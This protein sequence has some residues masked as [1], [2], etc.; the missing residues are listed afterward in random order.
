MQKGRC[1]DTVEGYPEPAVQQKTEGVHWIEFMNRKNWS[2]ISVTFIYTWCYIHSS[3]G[4][5]S[6][7]FQF[8]RLAV[9]LL[10]LCSFFDLSAN[11]SSSVNDQMLQVLLEA[12]IQ[13]LGFLVL[14]WTL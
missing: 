9:Q 1:G 13:D 2:E 4:S 5:S 14:A 11:S 7:V 10:T 6:E 12:T 3:E 8:Q